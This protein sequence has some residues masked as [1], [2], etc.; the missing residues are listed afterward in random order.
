MVCGFFFTGCADG[1]SNN[2]VTDKTV[3][4]TGVTLNETAFGLNPDDTKDLTATVSPANATNKRVSWLSSVPRVARVDN[5]GVVTALTDGK[6]TITVI[7]DDGRKTAS[8]TVTVSSIVVTGVTL[9]RTQLP[10]WVGGSDTLTAT[11]SPD[12]APNKTVSWETSDSSKVTVDSNG[13]VTAIAEGTATITARTNNHLAAHC[14]V[15][16]NPVAVTGVTLE[17]IALELWETRRLTPTFSPPNAT[18]KGVTW[19]SDDTDVVTVSPTGN[20]TGVDIGRATIT[21][22][23]VDGGHKGTCV[24]SVTLS[25]VPKIPM[26]WIV[27]TNAFTMGSP[28][29]EPDRKSNETQHQVTLTKGFS[30]GTYQ[31]S[32]AV[33]RTIMGYNPSY[34]SVEGN[35]WWD[36]YQWYEEDYLEYDWPVDSVNWYEAVE[37]CNKLSYA[38]G[39]DPVY[40]IKNRV[41]VKGYPITGATVEINWEEEEGVPVIGKYPNGYR[42]PTEAEWEYACRAG[43]TTIFN[44]KDKNTD[45]WGSNYITTDLANFDAYN[46][47]NGRS[48][49]GDDYDMPYYTCPGPAFYDP[50]QW[51]LYSMHGNVQEWCW[52]IYTGADYGATAATDPRGPASGGNTRVVR[53]GS[54]VTDPEYVRSASRGG[55][56]VDGDMWELY[57]TGFRVVRNAPVDD[58]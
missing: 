14:V 44:F 25:D 7:T 30:M 6:T 58:E 24:V 27:P 40:S 12:E 4:V 16:A 2:Q 41:P 38:S 23:T 31:I 49:Y 18:Y 48:C 35:D 11:V 52:D 36:W 13:M 56:P 34:F 5:D 17:N 28:G 43:T 19:E 54:F 39:F 8:C 46:N 42:L 50:N 32:Q 45:Q 26:K 1:D 3:A 51:G 15:T 21:V 10:L 9:D 47:Y 37:F 22:T 55:K 53:G 57:D 29:T 20:V 33:Y